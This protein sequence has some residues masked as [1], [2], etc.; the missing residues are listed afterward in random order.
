MEHFE[1]TYVGIAA[2]CR[3]AAKQPRYSIDLWNQYEAVRAG[4]DITNNMS[5]GWHN[6][7]R[8][9]VAKCHPD[10]YFALKDFQNE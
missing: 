10:L 9:A 8:I 2:R 3:R 7:G 5:E 1:N 6:R 4:L